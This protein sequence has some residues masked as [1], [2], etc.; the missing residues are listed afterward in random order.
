MRLTST[1]SFYL[2]G[3]PETYCLSWNY[4]MTPAPSTSTTSGT[5]TRATILEAFAGRPFLVVEDA[6]MPPN[7]ATILYHKQVIGRIEPIE[8]IAVRERGVTVG[9]WDIA[10]CHDYRGLAGYQQ[11][12]PYNPSRPSRQAAGPRPSPL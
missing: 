10:V 11:N 1:L 3:Q 8:R 4:G 6:N 7:Y 12:L 9:A 2:P 5:P